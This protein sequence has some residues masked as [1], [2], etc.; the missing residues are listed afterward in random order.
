MKHV[1]KVSVAK[2]VEVTDCVNEFKA[3]AYFA[4]LELLDGLMVA[5]GVE[6]DEKELPLLT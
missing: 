1:K 6:K 2:A 4:T 3:D 5:F